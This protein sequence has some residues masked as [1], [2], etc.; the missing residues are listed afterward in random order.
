MKYVEKSKAAIPEIESPQIGIFTP[1][2]REGMYRDCTVLLY[3]WIH[4]PLHFR[5]ARLHILLR[6]PVVLVD[7][8][9]FGSIRI[10]ATGSWRLRRLMQPNLRRGA[11]RSMLVLY[12]RVLWSLSK[13]SDSSQ[14]A[15]RN[16]S[17]CH[18]VTSMCYL[19]LMSPCQRLL[20]NLIQ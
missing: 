9:N 18:S 11:P 10:G 5:L 14:H 3:N 2:H 20:L 1:W 4:N 19:D 12:Y 6:L 7:S 17:H 16:A 8:T 15:Y 13:P